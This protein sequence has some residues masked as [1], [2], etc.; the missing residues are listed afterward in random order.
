MRGSEIPADQRMSWE[1]LGNPLP[2]G[3]E[4]PSFASLRLQ[5]GVSDNSFFTDKGFGSLG[6]LERQVLL[7]TLAPGFY[8]EHNPILRHT[9]LRRR[10]T[11]E[12]A[13]LLEL[14]AVSVHPDPKS[15]AAYSGVGFDGLGL[16]TNHPF[17]LAYQ[18]AEAFTAALQK[19]KQGASFM[20]TLL[21]QRICSSFASGRST[22]KKL[23][24]GDVPEEEEDA[25]LL[26]ETVADLTSVEIASLRTIIE[27]CLV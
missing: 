19:R 16:R 5:L 13:G 22:A 4:D 23:L 26:A 3:D 25:R 11:L 18:A 8:R 27:E 7:D 24:R 20:R 9:V 15:G 6:Y 14:T 2:P 12:A 10:K 1:W 21:L 17:D